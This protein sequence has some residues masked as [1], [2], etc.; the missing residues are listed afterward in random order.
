M[1]KTNSMK[2][3]KVFI[4][5]L[6]EQQYGVS[7]VQVLWKPPKLTVK[8]NFDAY[9]QAVYVHQTRPGKRLHAVTILKA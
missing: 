9:V 1:Q 6:P 3:Y 5:T 7:L 4:L 2:V 8:P